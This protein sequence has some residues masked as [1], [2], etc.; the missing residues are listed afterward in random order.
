VFFGYFGSQKLAEQ[1]IA[2]TKRDYGPGG[3]M[4]S[5]PSK[6]MNLHTVGGQAGSRSADKK[7]ERR[8]VSPRVKSFFEA[9]NEVLE[10]GGRVSDLSGREPTIE[11]G[12]LEDF[13]SACADGYERA[14]KVKEGGMSLSESIT[15]KQLSEVNKVIDDYNSNLSKY[16]GGPRGKAFA[17]F[18]R[19][20]PL[21]PDVLRRAKPWQQALEAQLRLEREKDRLDDE[22]ARLDNERALLIQEGR[23]LRDDEASLAQLKQ[24]DSSGNGPYSAVRKGYEDVVGGRRNGISS[25]AEARAFA[26]PSGRVLDKDGNVVTEA[27]APSKEIQ[28]K[29][30]ELAR[31][32]QDRQARIERYKNALNSHNAQVQQFEGE[33][34]T[35]TANISKLKEGAY[36]PPS[37]TK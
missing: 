9:L 16:Q 15:E 4:E 2:R 14:R 37:D 12:S 21:S 13:M 10:I 31:R 11:R 32:R 1:E 5:A 23:S 30:A 35:H 25:Y 33:N 34:S 8:K 24:S 17:R 3:Q 26:G 27:P 18:P 20:A 19:I 6:P 29:E 36:N 7:Q 28:E 22:K